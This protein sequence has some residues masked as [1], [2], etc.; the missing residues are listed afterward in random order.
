MTVDQL[1]QLADIE[2]LELRNKVLRDKYLY[3]AELNENPLILDLRND[4]QDYK[5]QRL[6][7]KIKTL[8]DHT[9]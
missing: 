1:H 9:D 4:F 5:Y 6:N 7:P 8:L 3:S 2:T